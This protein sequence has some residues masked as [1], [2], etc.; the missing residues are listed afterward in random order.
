MILVIMRCSQNPHGFIVPIAQPC[1]PHSLQSLWK[2]TFK[3]L[4]A[5]S[6]ECMQ[7][8]FFFLNSWG[9]L[10]R[11]VYLVLLFQIYT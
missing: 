3:Q 7:S 11:I 5:P 1:R 2:V 6:N 10:K 8:L 9:L 4:E